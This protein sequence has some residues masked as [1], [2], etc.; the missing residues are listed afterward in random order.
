MFAITSC[1]E[2]IR[3]VLDIFVHPHTLLKLQQLLNLELVRC[4]F[5]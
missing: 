4:F 5:H 1:A 3:K 2:R